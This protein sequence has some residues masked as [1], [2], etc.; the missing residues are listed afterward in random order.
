MLT[1][2]GGTW[3]HRPGSGWGLVGQGSQEGAKGVEALPVGFE[4]SS[5]QYFLSPYPPNWLHSTSPGPWL[6]TISEAVGLSRSRWCLDNPAPIRRSR[7]PL[8]MVLLSGAPRLPAAAIDLGPVAS[9]TAW[10]QETQP[11]QRW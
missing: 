8:Q 2:G 6:G 4:G 1:L 11:G 5:G 7:P 3:G 10:C 9:N